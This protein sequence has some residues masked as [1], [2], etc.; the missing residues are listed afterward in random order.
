MKPGIRLAQELKRA[1]VIAAV[2]LLAGAGAFHAYALRPSEARLEALERSIA[3]RTAAAATEPRQTPRDEA[4]ARLAQ[5]Y[6]YFGTELSYVDWLARFYAAA[7]QTGVAPQRVEYRNVE[8]QGIPLVLHE[9]SVPA[10]G[11]YA[12]IRAFSESVLANVP[13]AS[14]DQITFRRTAGTD[15][16]IE[17]D[18][19]FTLYL[20]RP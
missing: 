7:S 9:L 17:A 3:K 1:P 20:A 18:L 2:V 13:V 6:A 8:P 10:S 15:S 5:F 16:E 4:A 19:R 11:S 12:K 14:L